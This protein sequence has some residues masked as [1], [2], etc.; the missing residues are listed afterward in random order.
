MSWITV[1][2]LCLRQLPLLLYRHFVLNVSYIRAVVLSIVTAG[3]C[4][5]RFPFRGV[6]LFRSGHHVMLLSPKLRLSVCSVC[7]YLMT[8]QQLFMTGPSRSAI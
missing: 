1:H 8:L 4:Y 7:L 6:D 3:S 2:P 5:L